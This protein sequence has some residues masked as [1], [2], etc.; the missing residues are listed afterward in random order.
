MAISKE[1]KVEILSEYSGWLKRSKAVIFTQ[2]TGLNSKDIEALRRKMRA[3]GGEMHVLKNTLGKKAFSDAGIKLPDD[4]FT[5]SSAVNF[6]F[7]DPADIA[8]AIIEFAKT[9]EHVKVKGGSLGKQALSATDVQALAELPP[10][11]VV[12]ATLLGTIMAPAS[13]LARI[14]AEPG[15]SLAA[16]LQANV[17]RQTAPAAEAEAAA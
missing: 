5:G 8:K 13:Q 15:R 7:N 6:A 1:R 9:S 17:D 4:L 11:P 16:V 2:Y 14:L 10:L 12:R 3:A